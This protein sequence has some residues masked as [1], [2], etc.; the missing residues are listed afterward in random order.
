MGVTLLLIATIFPL[1]KDVLRIRYIVDLTTT[2]LR[3]EET[4]FKA[5]SNDKKP[6][7]GI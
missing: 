1:F 4:I 3:E 5:Y 2:L 7:S 6:A